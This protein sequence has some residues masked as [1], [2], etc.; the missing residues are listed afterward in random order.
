ML[1][2]LEILLLSYTTLVVFI[3]ISLLKWFWGEMHNV[4]AMDTSYL[5]SNSFDTIF[6]LKLL[7]FK[8]FSLLIYYL[9][10]CEYLA[11][12]KVLFNL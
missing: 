2:I 9:F 10:V 1:F 3:V 6:S 5:G 4:D 12:V 11:F 7:S 8:H